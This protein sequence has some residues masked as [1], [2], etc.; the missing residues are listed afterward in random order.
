LMQACSNV[1]KKALTLSKSFASIFDIK[2][3]RK[4]TVEAVVK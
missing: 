4:K 2:I 3:I 1:M